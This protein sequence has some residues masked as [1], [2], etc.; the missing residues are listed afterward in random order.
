MTLALS[1]DQIKSGNDDNCIRIDKGSD[2]NGEV[3][4]KAKK[5]NNV[6]MFSESD[7]EDMME[8]D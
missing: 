6:D 4:H 2:A 3:E 8:Q 7:D 1:I 5:A